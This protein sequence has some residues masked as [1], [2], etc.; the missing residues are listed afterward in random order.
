MLCVVPD[1]A[2]DNV[3]VDYIDL[4]IGGK[5][6]RR[7]MWRWRRVEVMLPA[8]A[9]DGVMGKIRLSWLSLFIVLRW[10]YV[11]PAVRVVAAGGAV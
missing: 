5:L 4:V 6:F 11:Y 9:A 10:R 1:S 2:A 8:M 7:G 3:Y